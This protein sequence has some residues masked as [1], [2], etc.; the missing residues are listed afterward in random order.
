MSIES[1]TKKFYLISLDKIIA[2]RL[3]KGYLNSRNLPDS[4]FYI[5]ELSDGTMMMEKTAYRDKRA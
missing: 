4:T 5:E 3:L 2:L 1:E